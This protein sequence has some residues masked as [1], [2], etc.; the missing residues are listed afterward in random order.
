MAARVHAT[1]GY[2][3]EAGTPIGTDPVRTLVVSCSDGRFGKPVTLFLENVLGLPPYDRLF[4]PGGAGSIASTFAWGLEKAVNEQLR[5][6]IHAHRVNRVI[7]LSHQ[8]CGFY[9]THL[10]VD[11]AIVEERRFA[12]LT[13]ALV[14]VRHL[15][16]NVEVR[17]YFARF[18]GREVIFET[19]S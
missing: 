11:P 9:K 5:F 8:D 7:L 15:G 2:I 14:K 4:V 13:Q 3:V 12:D 1:P 18:E 10:R 16:I 19:L 6:L 17:A